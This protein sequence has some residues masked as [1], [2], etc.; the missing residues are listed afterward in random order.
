MIKSRH[1]R[2]KPL[3]SNYFVFGALTITTGYYG[4]YA[5]IH[6]TDINP[7]K[8]EEDVGGWEFSHSSIIVDVDTIEEKI[9]GE[10]VK[11]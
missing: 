3:N 11:L 2:A 10:W 6:T 8:G 7:E 4:G 9:D 5:I 1:Y